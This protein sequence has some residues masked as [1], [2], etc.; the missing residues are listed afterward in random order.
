MLFIA[1]QDDCSLAQGTTLKTLMGY[2]A[3]IITCI[4]CCQCV[5]SVYIE[6]NLSIKDTLNKR[7][8]SNKR[9]CL[10][11]L[12]HRA[13]YRSTSELGTPLIYSTASWVPKVSSVERFHRM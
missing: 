10:Q 11:S 3:D 7:H 8:L 9:H 4:G 13:V 2:G 12:P 5:A 6:W 1:L